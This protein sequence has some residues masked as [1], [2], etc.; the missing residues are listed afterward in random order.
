MA[1]PNYDLYNWMLKTY[2]MPAAEWYLKNPTNKPGANPYLPKGAYVPQASAGSTGQVDYFQNFLNSLSVEEQKEVQDFGLSEEEK[3]ELGYDYAAKQK[4]NFGTPLAEGDYVAGGGLYYSPSFGQY[5]S[6]YTKE[7]PDADQVARVKEMMA[8][9]AAGTADPSWANQDLS[10]LITQKGLGGWHVR[11]ATAD[12]PEVQRYGIYNVGRSDYMQARRNE[13]L[14][15]NIEL[16]KQQADQGVQDSQQF[17]DQYIA[18]GKE[19]TDYAVETPTG[20]RGEIL[21]AQNKP[22]EPLRGQKTDVYYDKQMKQFVPELAPGRVINEI[23]KRAGSTPEPVDVRVARAEEKSDV[24]RERL[25]QQSEFDINKERQ[26]ASAKAAETYRRSAAEE[27][28]F[29]AAA[30]M[31]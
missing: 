8:Q 5:G 3:Q 26:L 24:Q 30:R 27:D 31:G 4:L 11:G 15:K 2:G 28:P 10:N 6:Y 29:R 18:Q 17:L 7:N 21:T 13:A 14:Q 23:I 16:L 20:P 12:D 9:Q 1:E 22:T 19:G 25:A